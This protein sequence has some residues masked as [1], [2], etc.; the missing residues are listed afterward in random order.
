MWWG[1]HK[2][3]VAEVALRTASLPPARGRWR[4]VE[5]RAAEAAGGEA[6]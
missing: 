3:G 5:L 2:G 6:C 1:H 4:E